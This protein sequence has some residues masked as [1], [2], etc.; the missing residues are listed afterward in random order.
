M[1]SPPDSTGVVELA[2]LSARRAS[3]GSRV[4]ENRRKSLVRMSQDYRGITLQEPELF[5]LGGLGKQIL[6]LDD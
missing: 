6:N 3:E 4:E 2:D 5:A 1:A